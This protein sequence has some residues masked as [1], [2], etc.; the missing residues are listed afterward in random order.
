MLRPMMELVDVALPVPLA[1]IF[2]YEVREDLASRATPG[3]RVVCPFGS[4]RAIG[5]VLASRTGEP[6][7]GVKRVVSVLDEEP[8]VPLD[9]LAF[10][11]DLASYYLAPIGEVTRLALPPIEKEA[12]RAVAEPTL[13]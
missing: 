2:T 5:V 12:A 4:R 6:P 1:R 9:L 8:A 3:A 10:L 11:R 7:E 13:F